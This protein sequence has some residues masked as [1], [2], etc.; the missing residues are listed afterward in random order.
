QVAAPY[1]VPAGVPTRMHTADTP[2]S[3]RVI[4]EGSIFH[5]VDIETDPRV[6]PF[7]FQTVRTAGIRSFL[8]VPMKRDDTPIGSIV[9]M[10]S[11]AGNFADREI[12]LLKTFA[13]Q[14]VIAVENVRLF[15]ELQEKNRALTTALDQQ[16]ATGEI[17]RVISSS[18]T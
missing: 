4:R 6:T 16:T 14:A 12:A 18:P 9:V 5:V 17:L 15:T 7:A 8:Q 13:D 10:R 3:T 1:N 2:H 11:Q